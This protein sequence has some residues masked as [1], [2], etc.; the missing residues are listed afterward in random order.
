MVASGF[1]FDLG[2]LSSCVSS[3]LAISSPASGSRGGVV[4]NSDGLYLSSPEFAGDGDL[5][6]EIANSLF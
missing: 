4:I 6:K 2:G 5:P 1:H 3:G